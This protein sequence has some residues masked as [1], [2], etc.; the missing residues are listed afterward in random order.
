MNERKNIV[1]KNTKVDWKLIY[2]LIFGK[3][4]K[5]KYNNDSLNNTK[6]TFSGLFNSNE[7]NEENSQFDIL[8]E[9]CR[10]QT[11]IN[12]IR[13]EMK[14]K[15]ECNK[16]Q[17]PNDI[18]NTKNNKNKK[19]NKIPEMV[20]NIKNDENTLKSVYKVGISDTDRNKF[21]PMIIKKL[22]KKF[23]IYINRKKYELM[24]YFNSVRSRSYDECF[25]SEK[26]SKKKMD[27]NKKIKFGITNK[28]LV[29]SKYSIS[30]E[31]SSNF[32]KN[33]MNDNSAVRKT[34]SNN[35]LLKSKYDQ[36]K[37]FIPNR[38]KSLIFRGKNDSI[39]MKRRKIS[40]NDINMN[41]SLDLNTKSNSIYFNEY[42]F[43]N[44]NKQKTY[45]TDAKFEL[46]KKNA[47]I[48]IND[49]ILFKV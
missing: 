7:M 18:I 17:S 37:S 29:K 35:L 19:T 32:V 30:E 13:L 40:S 44:I 1:K 24:K 6:T 21:I 22:K 33:Q 25:L 8:L 39:L 20:L 31:K 36:R 11:F 15:Y 43:N 48:I 28:Q 23:N 16:N 9:K 38:R 12:K 3:M 49:E 5:N 10:F 42:E 14:K 27:K 47:K 2:N 46:F 41:L 45:M 26:R 34:T 4:K